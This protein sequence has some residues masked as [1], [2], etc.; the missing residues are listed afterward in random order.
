[1]GSA[2]DEHSEWAH[3][4]CC[5]CSGG[6]GWRP[7][8]GL[9]LCTMGHSGAAVP[10]LLPEMTGGEAKAPVLGTQPVFKCSSLKSLLPQE[11]TLF[12][13]PIQKSKWL[14]DSGKWPMS[15]PCCLGPCLWAQDTG[16]WFL[17]CFSQTW[18]HSDHF[19]GASVGFC[20]TGQEPSWQHFLVV[21]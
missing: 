15:G 2:L 6:F 4:P 12:M 14:V 11:S 20:Y 7:C 3:K 5:C 13:W 18:S 17:V 8:A 9:S 10:A 16:S 1:M 21:R 19:Y